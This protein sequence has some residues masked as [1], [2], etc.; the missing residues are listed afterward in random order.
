MPTQTVTVKSTLKSLPGF[1]E[2]LARR[3]RQRRRKFGMFPAGHFYSPVPAVEDVMRDR[4]RLYGSMP[5]SIPG[6]DLREAEQFELVQQFVPF[7]EELPFGE[8]PKA[9]LRYHFVPA[10]YSY[11]DAIFLYGM[12]R[13]VKPARLVEI[14]SGYSSCVCLD[15]NEHFFDNGIELTFI[16]PFP[17]RL[18]SLMRED[19]PK[20]TRIVPKRLQDVDLN[21][22]TSLQAGDILVVDS[23]HVAK[24]GS[25]VNRIF[26]EVLPALAS[27]VHIHFHD[28]HYPF[29]YPLDWVQ[30]GIAW[31]ESYMLRAF[32]QYNAA[33]DVELMSTYIILRQEAFFREKMPLCL[34]NPG[35]N[36]WLYKK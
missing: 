28:I 12:I 34:K 36:I 16:D 1:R 18:A 5:E 20:H 26:F 29:E 11:T 10:P 4:E 8:E 27:G 30:H 6:V 25:D 21:V 7:Y 31:N 19:D 14:G 2:L 15:T 33:F 9:G 22:F 32:L 3:D 35:G 13:H 17:R 24:I 23:T